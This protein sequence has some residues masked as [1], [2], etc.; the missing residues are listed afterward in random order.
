M[1]NCMIPMNRISKFTKLYSARHMQNIILNILILL[2]IGTLFSGC[3]L[4]HYYGGKSPIEIEQQEN[5][6]IWKQVYRIQAVLW[7]L[8][9]RVLEIEK[10]TN[11]LEK[12]QNKMRDELGATKLS[13]IQANKNNEFLHA[14]IMQIKSESVGKENNPAEMI[15]SAEIK[16]EK[17][18]QKTRTTKVTNE[19]KKVGPDIQLIL[20]HDIKYYKISE[21]QDRVLVYV[22]A[23]NNPQLQTLLGANPRL[24]LDFLNTRNRDKEK[25]EIK[26]DGNFIKRIRIRSYQEPLQ[27]V[28]VVFDMMPN[29]KYS[30]ERTFAKKENIY[31]FD[32]MAK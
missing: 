23:M 14:E 10:K 2:V 30:I 15:R 3:S 9:K 16:S 31:A 24:V 29:K 17:E 5:P 27:K 13:S 11:E 18:M 25:Y 20:I 7:P 22:N 28:R 26:T 1:P 32:L 21:T 19:S 4:F 8:E 6:E 12:I